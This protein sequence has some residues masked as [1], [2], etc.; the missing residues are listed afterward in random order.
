MPA[1]RRPR[2][3]GHSGQEGGGSIVLLRPDTEKL[4]HNYRKLFSC[5]TALY[6]LTLIVVTIG[7]SGGGKPCHDDY[8]VIPILA[9]KGGNVAENDKKGGN[10]GCLWLQVG[11]DGLVECDGSISPIRFLFGSC[12]LGLGWAGL[13]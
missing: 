6:S 4:C 13:G 3:P 12:V 1:M 2:V 7:V 9:Q 11:G 8:D 5:L 10:E